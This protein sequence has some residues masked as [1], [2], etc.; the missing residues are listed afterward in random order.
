MVP[1]Q[2]TF[3]IL[4]VMILFQ[5]FLLYKKCFK[6][7]VFPLWRGDPVLELQI[8]AICGAVVRSSSVVRNSVSADRNGVAASRFLAAAAA[9]VILTPLRVGWPPTP[10]VYFGSSHTHMYIYIYIHAHIYIYI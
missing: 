4:A 2:Q 10:Q 8:A 7:V 6:I 9:C 3:L 5:N 1:W